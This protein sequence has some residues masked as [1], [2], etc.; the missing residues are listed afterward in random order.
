MSQYDE[1]YAQVP[2]S[3]LASRFG[4]DDA[5]MS[6]AVHAALPALLG[7]LEANAADPAGADSIMRALSQHAGEDPRDVEQVD[8]ADGEKI[9][10]HIY[11]ESTDQVLRQ[12]GGLG[13][14]AGSLV[15]KLLPIL[16]P[17]VLSWLAGKM[18]GAGGLGGVLGD[19]FGGRGRGRETAQAPAP[20]DLDSGPLFPGGQGASSGPVE[21]PTDL[22]ASPGS[23]PG[24]PAGSN[25]LKDILG[26]VL[27]GASSGGGGN[28]L[29]DLLGGLLG[30]GRR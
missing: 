6:E 15:Q 8:A 3:Q 24:T 19:I 2:I 1:L 13:G 27:G 7:G 16:A 18:G 29:G 9:V 23:T 20:S 21:S 12:L 30:R 10:G 4:V 25:P 22:G 5:E 28:V 26:D 11:G 17:I 14:T